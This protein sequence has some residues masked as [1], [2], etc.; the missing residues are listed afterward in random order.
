MT[1]DHINDKFNLSITKYIIKNTPHEHLDIDK[2]FH[3]ERKKNNKIIVDTLIDHG[4][5]IVSSNDLS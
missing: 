4:N 5:T 2:E 3:I 1:T